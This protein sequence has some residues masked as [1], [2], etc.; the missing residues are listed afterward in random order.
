M[1]YLAVRQT[2]QSDAVFH[3][4]KEINGKKREDLI[5]W[6]KFYLFIYI[7]SLQNQAHI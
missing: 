3:V 4:I 7:D 1:Q 6:W 2:D 5:I